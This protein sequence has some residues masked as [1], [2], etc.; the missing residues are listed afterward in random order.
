MSAGLDGLSLPGKD[1]L[2]RAAHLYQP[3]TR[4]AYGELEWHALLRLLDAEPDGFPSYA[5]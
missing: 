1:V 2:N 3:G 5:S 4:R